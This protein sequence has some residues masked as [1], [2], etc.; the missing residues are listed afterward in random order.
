MVKYAVFDLDGTLTR[1][2][3]LIEVLCFLRSR[4]TV[5]LNLLLLLPVL[6]LSK[7]KLI[8]SGNVKAKL[9]YNC[10]A[11]FD[12]KHIRSKCAL[13]SEQNLP[14]LITP[15]MQARLNW[16]V[17]QGHQV[18]IATASLDL[19]VNAWCKANSYWVVCTEA[20]FIQGQLQPVF[21]SKNCKGYEKLMKIKA[22]LKDKSGE[23]A[24]GYGDTPPDLYFLRECKKQFYRKFNF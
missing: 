4:I 8:D 24:Y 21:K 1:K 13:F 14:S 23:L 10:L 6:I 12:E 18:I 9:I 5:R 22:L 16:H 2:D 3:T 15:N 20:L 17:E 19:W 11:K 7:L